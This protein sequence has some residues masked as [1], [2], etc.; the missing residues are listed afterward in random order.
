MRGTVGRID[1]NVG[2]VAVEPDTVCGGGRLGQPQIA[3][4]AVCALAV[5]HCLVAV[6]SVRLYE[7]ADNPRCRIVRG[8]HRTGDGFTWV[9]IISL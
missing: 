6:G 7:E 3:G 4:G 2:I 5:A 1:G 9:D 8:S